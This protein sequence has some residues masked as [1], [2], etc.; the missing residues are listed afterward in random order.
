MQTIVLPI[1]LK[2]LNINLLGDRI[3]GWRSYLILLQVLMLCCLLVGL[4]FSYWIFFGAPVAIYNL[5]LDL[6]RRSRN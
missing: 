6:P 1:I 3:N 5:T 4:I 2:Q